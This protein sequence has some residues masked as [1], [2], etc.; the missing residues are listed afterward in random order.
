M[1]NIQKTELQKEKEYKENILPEQ[2]EEL[3]EELELEKEKKELISSLF[4]DW[5]YEYNIREHTFD[6]ISGSGDMYQFKEGRKGDKTFVILDG[7]HPE[8]EKKLIENSRE[9]HNLEP[10]HLEVRVLRDGVYRW[11]AMTTKI[12]Y[13]KD[14]RPVSLL[15]KITDIDVKKREE[16][17]LKAQAMRDSM[18]GLLNRAAFQER[19]EEMLARAEREALTPAMLIVDID[20]F[21]Q[22]N[23]NYGHLYGDTAIVSMAE[24]L[25]VVFGETA[26]IGRFGGDEFTVFLPHADRDALE[27][28]I[29]K[30]REVYAGDIAQS[31]EG[32]KVTCSIG[33]SCYGVDGTTVEELL[34]NADSALYYIKETGRDAYAICTETIKKKFA[35]GAE[36]VLS[37]EPKSEKRN[38]AEEI[39]EFALELLEGSK[40]LKSA[41]NM[42][43]MKVGKRFNLAVV[44]VREYNNQGMPV[45]S[46]LWSNA[47]KKTNPDAEVMVTPEERKRVCDNYR[48]NQPVEFRDTYSL[49]TEGPLYRMYSSKGI[50]ALYQCPF[51]S[52]GE[53]FGYIAYVDNKVRE[54]TEDEKQS[55]SLIARIIGNYLAREYAYEKIARKIEL[56]KSMDEVTGLL[57]YEKFKEVTQTMLNQCGKDACYAVIST[58]F[59]HFKYFNEVYGFRSGDEVLKDFANLV[60]KRN[61]YAVAGCRDYADTFIVMVSINSPESLYKTAVDWN[62][63]FIETQNE[64]YMDCKLEL[65]TGIYV[66]TNPEAGIIQ[67]IDNA[68]T[69]RKILKE[70]GE[71]G[72]LMFEP[73]MRVN[74][75]REI[76]IQHMIDEA[77]DNC[78]FQLYLQPKFSLKSGELIGA[79]G[80][81]RW[82]RPDGEV[83]L[84]NDFI[85]ALEKSGK[86]VQLDFYMYEQVLKQ[87]RKW[88]EAG[89]PLVPISV[90]LS[91]HHIKDEHLVDKLVELLDAYGVESRMIEIE[92]T[93]SAFIDDQD[94]LIEVMKEIK[95]RGFGVSIDDF[96]TGYSSLSMLTELPADI[97]KLD[98]EFLKHSDSDITKGMLNNVIRLIKD[99][100]MEVICEGVEEEEQAEFLAK[101]GCNMGQGFYFSRP[102]PMGDFEKLYFG[103]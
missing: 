96:G 67:A 100:R 57:K 2:V 17:R 70:K 81:S 41:M 89:Y 40:D 86:I 102:I 24:A 46:Y 59:V 26:A 92:I 47:A 98:K 69:A 62:R 33:A 84:P 12:L 97:V 93:E 58:D 6:T 51:F 56:M 13:G 14:G 29:I 73:S 8:D 4:D 15:G 72:I 63:K 42:L 103:K 49:P 83:V 91:R 48:K 43:L 39:T 95:R 61:P 55:M 31:E 78:E 82:V 30:L 80:L 71:T 18:T 101:A 50:R 65:C 28:E 25:R 9:M 3:Q 99:N 76:A 23:D 20:K 64:K 45:I 66:I 21:K 27:K 77:I 52:E 68:N 7:L 5:I 44:S 34:K 37:E 74:R 16:L 53:V 54:W 60:A 10:V 35:E 94:A 19:A 90:N 88:K 38:I 1:R 22:I 79:E 87:Q 32:H 75:M 85:P 11:I 36:Q